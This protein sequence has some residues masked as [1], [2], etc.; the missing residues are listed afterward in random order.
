MHF[1]SSLLISTA[2]WS[3]VEWK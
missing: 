1:I 2:F 3:W